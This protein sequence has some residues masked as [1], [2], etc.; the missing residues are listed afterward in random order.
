MMYGVLVCDNDR[1]SIPEII[2][3]LAKADVLVADNHYRDGFIY[4]DV[5]AFMPHH[6][7]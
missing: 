4:F 3:V 6:Y 5:L 1:T 2:L 7:L